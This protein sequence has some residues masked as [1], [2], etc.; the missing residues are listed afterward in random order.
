MEGLKRYGQMINKYKGHIIVSPIMTG[1]ILPGEVQRKIVEEGWLRVGYAICHD[2]LEGRSSLLGRPPVREFLKDVAHFFGG[3]V[4][5]HTLGCRGAQFA[6]M[7]TISDLA[8]ASGRRSGVVLVDSLCHYTTCI[9]AEMAGLRVVEVPNTGYPEYRVTAEDYVKR[10]ESIREEEGIL[11]ALLVATHV[12]P[13][14]GNLSPVEEIGRVAEEDGIPYMVNAAYT[15][16]VLPVNMSEMR[17]DFLTVSAHK[18]MA[19]LGPLGFLI[20]SRDWSER[21]FKTSS[22]RMDWSG[23]EFG[24]KVPSL[25]GCSIGGLPLISAMYAFPHVAERVGRWEEELE[26]TRWFIREM[27]QIGGL[28]LLGERPHR[29]HLLHFETPVFW[30]ISKHHRRRGFFLAEE[31]IRRGIVGLQRGLSRHIKLSVYGL[32][33]EE[34]RKVRDAFQ[35][36]KEKYVERFDLTDYRG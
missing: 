33:M 36:I 1:G 12:D 28:K 29:H 7:K 3:E 15:A 16:G 24:K 25:F 26:K 21:L 35:E 27:E 11:P 30:E 22:L 31:M 9:A 23:R 4:A 5:E 13:Y 20:T 32:P 18:S 34:V 10:I 14:H 19:S 17:A 8:R 6:V 2:C